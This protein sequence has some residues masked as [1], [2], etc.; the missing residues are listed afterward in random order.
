MTTLFDIIKQNKEGSKS[1]IPVYKDG[2]LTKE[3]IQGIISKYGKGKSPL[4]AE[5]YIKVSNETGVPVELLLV[6][7]IQESSFGTAGRAVRTKNVGNVGNTDD[8]SARNIGSWEDGLRAQA[9][10]L[11]KEYGATSK[12]AVRGLIENGFVRTKDKARY[13][14]DP[15]YEKRLS[16]LLKT[17]TGQDYSAYTNSSSNNTYAEDSPYSKYDF[18]NQKL[19]Y[20]Q[21]NAQMES[22][23]AFQKAMVEAMQSEASSKIALNQAQTLAIEREQAEKLALQEEE[24]KRVEQE[25]IQSVLDEKNKQREMLMEVGLQAIP[26]FIERDETALRQLASSPMNF[27]F[28]GG[29][30]QLVQGQ[31]GGKFETINLDEVVVKAETPLT[32][33]GKEFEKNN[34][35]SEFVYG[36]PQTTFD[37]YQGRQNKYEK[38]KN[39]YIANEISKQY[40]GKRGRI[41]N[42]IRDEYGDEMHD[43]VITNSTNRDVRENVYDNFKSG[44]LNINGSFNPY[45]SNREQSKRGNVLLDRLGDIGDISSPLSVPYNVTLGKK[46]TNSKGE[47]DYTYSDAFSGVVPKE[48]EMTAEIAGDPLNLLGIGIADEAL[49]GFKSIKNILPITAKEQKIFSI[50]DLVNSNNYYRVIRGEESFNDIANKGIVRSVPPVNTNSIGKINLGGRPTAFPSFS[51]GKVSKEYA[52]GDP[53][54]YIIESN[55]D[56]IKVST[57]GRHGKGT[58][59]FPTDIEGNYINSLDAGKINVYKHL[60]EGKY[61]KVMNNIKNKQLFEKGGIFHKMYDERNKVNINSFKNRFIK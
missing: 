52:E 38:L 10:L 8:G 53:L 41:L 55:S 54:N 18:S 1:S 7:G 3:N 14:S 29:F 19:D 31:K 32:K 4:S 50:D 26:E 36:K 35:Y 25:Q 57:L 27:Q 48:R 34:N 13:A 49:K 21:M 47:T 24:K 16:G 5:N 46:V 45:R 51:K 56:K 59:Y 60:G 23:Q 6:Q 61:E 44:V 30:Q 2:G 11:K 40:S 33:L 37:S 22:N 42:S 20:S 17:I 28:Q 39:E 15:L 9:N 58:T 12:E 43:F